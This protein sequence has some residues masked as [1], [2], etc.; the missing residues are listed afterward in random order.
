MRPCQGAFCGRL[1]RIA[2]ALGRI[3]NPPLQ[4]A[5]RSTIPGWESWLPRADVGIRPYEYARKRY[6]AKK[7]QLLLGSWGFC[8]Y[9]PKIMLAV[10][11]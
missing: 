1:A 2:T 4:G 5:V 3:Y 11:K 9:K 7:S 8:D 6:S 10:W